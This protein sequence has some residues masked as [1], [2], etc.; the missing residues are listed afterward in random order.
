MITLARTIIS[1]A[2][3]ASRHFQFVFYKFFFVNALQL[4]KGC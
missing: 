3:K 4:M 1:T 2:Q